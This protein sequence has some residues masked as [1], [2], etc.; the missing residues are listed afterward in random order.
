[1][2][3]QLGSLALAAMML[4]GGVGVA[5]ADSGPAAPT[6]GDVTSA[7]DQAAP[8]VAAETTDA[9]IHTDA[10]SAAVTTTAGTTVDIPKDPAD[11]VV[12]DTP[13]GPP[14]SITI[15]GADTARDAKRT[16]D[17]TV[18][19]QGTDEQASTAVQPTDNGGV[20]FVTVIDGPNAPTDYRFDITLPDGAALEEAATPTGEPDG[21]LEIVGGDGST[22]SRIPAPWAKDAS[23]HDIP[24]AYTVEHSTIVMHV[25]HADAA[26][27]V[28][29]DP[30][31]TW[32][33]VTGTIYFTRA[34]TRSARNQTELQAMVGGL[35][36]AASG[37]L[38][39]PF[40]GGFSVYSGWISVKAGHYYDEG[41]CLKIKVPSFEVGSV[42]RG[43]RNCR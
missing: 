4:A 19:Y 30:M 17:G 5:Y 12:L 9:A 1:M 41:K 8:A 13:S 24:V 14:L 42:S 34:E 10:D 43:D 23:G 16:S 36:W 32:G 21:S 2:R 26:Y 22:L 33:W 20:R 11:P 40:C 37:G 3:R 38:L 31:F 7:I 28:V 29:A 27:P 39:A 18:V 15:D 35:C 25:N 6:A